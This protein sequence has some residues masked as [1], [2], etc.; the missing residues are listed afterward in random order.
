MAQYFL[1]NDVSMSQNGQVC[2]LRA[3]KFIDDASQNTA[4]IIA[5]GGVLAAA[6]PTIAAQ[7]A[8]LTKYSRYRGQGLMLDVAQ[9]LNQMEGGNI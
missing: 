8:L 1:C 4:Q 2:R 6:N 5:A 9:V 3:G 7:A